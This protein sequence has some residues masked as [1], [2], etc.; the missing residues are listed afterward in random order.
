MV[1]R[2]F[3]QIGNGNNL[4]TE[5]VLRCQRLSVRVEQFGQPLAHR[6]KSEQ[7]ELPNLPVIWCVFYCACR[8]ISHLSNCSGSRYKNGD[9]NVESGTIR[10][11]NAMEQPCEQ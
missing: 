4:R 10:L 5:A 2:T 9:D 8:R 1:N 3:Y 6:A 11:S 7:C